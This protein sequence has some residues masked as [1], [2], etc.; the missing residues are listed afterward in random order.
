M[1][2]I[3]QHIFLNLTALGLSATAIPFQDLP[4][5]QKQVLA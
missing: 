3:N 4:N 5:L 2:K 1:Q